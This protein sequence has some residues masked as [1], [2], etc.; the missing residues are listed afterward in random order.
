V[1]S[2]GQLR[3]RSRGKPATRGSG[4]GGRD[5]GQPVWSTFYTTLEATVR[6]FPAGVSFPYP[7]PAGRRTTYLPDI[8]M[9]PW[10]VDRQ[11]SLLTRGHHH[12]GARLGLQPKREITK[13]RPTNGTTR[14]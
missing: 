11:R 5:R 8:D 13:K 7:V 9:D 12:G 3:D 4:L 14:S 2:T 6:G 1:A 10:R